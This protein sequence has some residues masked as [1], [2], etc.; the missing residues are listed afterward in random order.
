MPKIER[1]ESV[2]KAIDEFDALGRERFLEKY[3]FGQSRTYFLVYGGKFYDSKAIYGAAYR[4]EN[5]SHGPLRP[6]DFCGGWTTVR[7]WLEAL[8]FEVRVQTSTSPGN[9]DPGA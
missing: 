6:S 9:L 2:L 4:F 3:G 5:S 8:G 7:K 1:R